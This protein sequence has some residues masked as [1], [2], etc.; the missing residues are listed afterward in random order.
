MFAGLS[1]CDPGDVFASVAGCKSHNVRCERC[2]WCERHVYG[3]AGRVHSRWMLLMV[4]H[5]PSPPP[6]F[7]L[8]HFVI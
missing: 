3:P 2:G 7:P 1:T 6:P 4:P 8:L 5:A